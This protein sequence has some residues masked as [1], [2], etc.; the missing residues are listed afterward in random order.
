MLVLAGL[1]GETAHFCDSIKSLYP[2]EVLQ[3]L[4]REDV[5]EKHNTTEGSNCFFGFL[6]RGRSC[7]CFYLSVEKSDFFELLV[8]GYSTEL[9]LKITP[10]KETSYFERESIL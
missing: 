1:R 6:T 2:S 4:H 8:P 7:S 5:L 3:Q 9:L 10:P